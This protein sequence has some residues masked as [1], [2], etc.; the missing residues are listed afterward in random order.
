MDSIGSLGMVPVFGIALAL[1]VRPKS[2][3][4]VTAAGLAISRAN[5]RFQQDVV[6]AL[7]YTACATITVVAPIGATIL[8]PTWMEP[9]LLS[10]K[11]WIARHSTAVS[12]TM[13]I[14]V[15]GFVIWVGL[16]S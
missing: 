7:L 6:L 11:T 1:N 15:G 16:S 10:M 3:L 5:Q 4:L 2:V 13:T 14:L 8:A 9:R 12:A